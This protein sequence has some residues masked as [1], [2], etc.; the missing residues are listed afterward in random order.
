MARINEDPSARLIRNLRDRIKILEQQIQDHDTRTPVDSATGTNTAKVQILETEIRNL[1]KGLHDLQTAKTTSW[2]TKICVSETKC[3][4]A[5]QTLAEY[6]V[7]C[8]SD[9]KQ[10]C[11][12]NVNEVINLIQ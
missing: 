4:E 2:Q 8:S 3:I 9:P 5:E 11:L 1:R 6:G 10:P 12:I 7:A